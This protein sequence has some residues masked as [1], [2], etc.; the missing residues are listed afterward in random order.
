MPERKISALN[1]IGVNPSKLGALEEYALGISKELIRRGHSAFA[2]FL[3]FPPPEI[4]RKFRDNGIKVLEFDHKSGSLSFTRKLRKIIKENEINILHV[5]FYNIYSPIFVFSILDT[6]A[7]LIYSDQYSRVF[8]PSM[9]L[10][11]IYRFSRNRVIQKFIHKIVADAQFIKECH[12]QDDFVKSNKVQVIYNGVNIG[13]FKRSSLQSRSRL[14]SEFKMPEE[15]RLI[16]TIAQC[17][18]YK[19]LDYLLEAAKIVLEKHHNTFF[20]IIGDGPDRKKLEKKA[21]DLNIEDR[22][23]FTGVRVDTENFLGSADIFV[24]LSLWEEA[25]AFSLLEA[26]ASECP[27]VATNI[28]AIPESVQDGVTGILVPPR[29]AGATATAILKLLNDE[30]L[31]LKMGRAARKRVEDNFSLRNWINQTIHLYENA[32]K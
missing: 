23:F 6:T 24:L 30:P 21:C 5:T 22:C 12:I 11:S 9:N 13:R 10:K 20:F 27:V 15:S 7:R 25:F 26:M 28:G 29:D 31:R 3:N 16:V 17:I 1:L 4:M 8:H 19:G 14:L 32:V 2:G 18:P